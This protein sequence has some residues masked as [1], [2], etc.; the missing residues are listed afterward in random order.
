MLKMPESNLHI[1]KLSSIGR[2]NLSLGRTNQPRGIVLIFKEEGNVLRK[3]LLDL[4]IDIHVPCYEAEFAVG[5]MNDSL[6][7]H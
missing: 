5:D 1:P 2:Q 3:I 7:E 4:P 6:S